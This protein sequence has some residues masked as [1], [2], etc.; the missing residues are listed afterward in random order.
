MFFVGQERGEKTLEKKEKKKYTR[1]IV[2][3]GE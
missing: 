2:V 1:R 3:G